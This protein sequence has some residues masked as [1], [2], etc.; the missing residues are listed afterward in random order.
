[1]TLPARITGDWMDSLTNDDLLVAESTLHQAFSALDRE[2][3][4]R[5]GT[6][7]EL[8]RG[9]A[10]LM[11]AWDRWSRVNTATRARGLHPRRR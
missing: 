7:Y 6:K 1:M 3:R 2:E 8:M 9:P 10:E 11:S 5:T 4:A